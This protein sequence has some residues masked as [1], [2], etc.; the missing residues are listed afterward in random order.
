MV[1]TESLSVP[2]IGLSLGVLQTCHQLSKLALPSPELK[3]CGLTRVSN[4]VA[5]ADSQALTLGLVPTP[6]HFPLYWFCVS[7]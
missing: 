4:M 7:T 6:Y 2:R 1:R 5:T 3:L